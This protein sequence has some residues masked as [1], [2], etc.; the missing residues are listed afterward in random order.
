LKKRPGNL[1]KTKVFGP[2]SCACGKTPIAFKVV[3]FGPFRPPNAHRLRT[4]FSGRRRCV[5]AFNFA[6]QFEIGSRRSGRESGDLTDRIAAGL[7][8]GSN[9]IPTVQIRVKFSAFVH[10]CF[11]TNEVL[12]EARPRRCCPNSKPKATQRLDAIRALARARL[13]QGRCQVS[14]RGDSSGR[15][16]RL[17]VRVHDPA[18]VADLGS[19]TQIIHHG[20]MLT[21]ASGQRFRGQ[22]QTDLVAVLETVGDGL[23]RGGRSLRAPPAVRVP[24]RHGL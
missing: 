14:A 20:L 22:V 2:F 7:V 18:R 4:N 3:S 11:N 24:R 6:S 1:G 12:V 9:E 21:P 8:R 5:K 16:Q 19:R 13:Q 15:L 23:G 17:Q 10:V